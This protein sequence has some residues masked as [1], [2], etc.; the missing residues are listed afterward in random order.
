MPIDE[1]ID[2]PGF[3]WLPENDVERFPGTLTIDETGR[4]SLRLFAETDNTRLDRTQ[5]SLHPLLARPTGSLVRDRVH[6]LIRG[7][8]VTL[9]RC[10][11]TTMPWFA[12]GIAE[13][14]YMVSRAYIGAW[15]GVDETPTFSRINFRIDSLQ[16]WLMVSGLR[17]DSDV[18]KM[19]QGS[20]TVS[21]DSPEPITVQLS[22][23]ITFSFKFSYS[24][25][26]VGV[27]P[28]EATF[29]QSAYLSLQA[30]SVVPFDE[31]EPTATTFKRFLSFAADQACDVTSII[32]FSPE[33]VHDGREVPVKIYTGQS[34]L[35]Q[36]TRDPS[37]T[38]ML[39]TFRDVKS[40]FP[41]EIDGWLRTI[42][43][44]E[45]AINL[46]DALMVNAYRYADGHFLATAQAIEALHRRLFPTQTQ[47]SDQNFSTLVDA[48]VATAPATRR[49]WVQTR[50][51]H[52]NEPT[53]GQRVGALLK[54][55]A[56]YF[57]TK[58]ERNRF[59]RDVVGI[60]NRLTHL[61][62][63][64]DQQPTDMKLLITTQVKLEVL[65]QLHMLRQ[66]G[67]DDDSIDAIAQKRLLPKMEINFL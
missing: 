59:R 15:Y 55:F 30:H 23:E 56:S 19:L 24:L 37:W 36:P 10:I 49:E 9:D 26:S 31:L 57:G 32:G 21:F 14:S 1:P 38:R 43:E 7:Q 34:D 16:E 62:A 60:R 52:A 12:D 6:G 20:A 4:I 35:S 11:P 46:Y 40:R 66:L 3:F 58:K 64:G 28:A 27:A 5:A 13:G 29:T 41:D 17:M 48:L 50:L 53:F 65:F 18:D 25:P 42:D 61:P 8:A 47:M 39:F 54:P 44:L 67:F 51:E 63:N 33:L 22:S 2:Q 45:P